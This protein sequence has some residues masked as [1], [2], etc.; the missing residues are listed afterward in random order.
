MGVITQ[1]SQNAVRHLGY[2]SLSDP[3]TPGGDLRNRSTANPHATDGQTDRRTRAAT[4]RL[5]GGWKE[6]REET[7]KGGGVSVSG[8]AP[9][10]TNALPRLRRHQHQRFP[11]VTAGPSMDSHRVQQQFHCHQDPPELLTDTME[12]KVLR[13]GTYRLRFALSG[14]TAHT[15]A[16]KEHDAQHD[17]NRRGVGSGIFVF[18]LLGGGGGEVCRSMPTLLPMRGVF[19]A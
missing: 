11:S 16:M 17:T 7:K 9:P 8:R 10:S 4:D 3:S 13:L 19:R 18:L 15:S 1:H 12:Q 2:R 6:Q 5:G 14:P